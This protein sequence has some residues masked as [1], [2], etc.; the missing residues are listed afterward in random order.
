MKRLL[1]DSH[2]LLWYD[3]EPDRL[4][5]RVQL[6]VRRPSTQVYVSPVSIYEL[7]VKLEKQRLPQAAR[8]LDDLRTRLTVYGFQILPLTEH[9]ALRAARLPWEHRDPFDRLL[10][11]QALEERLCLVSKDGAFH[12]LEHLDVLW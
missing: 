8:I 2:V 4:S 6:I 5:D 3:D 10:A 1:L 12:T 11:A 7:G 9:H